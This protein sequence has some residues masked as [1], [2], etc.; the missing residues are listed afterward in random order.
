M[1]TNVKL[2]KYQIRT[3]FILGE[4]KK[5]KTEKLTPNASKCPEKHLLTLLDIDTI[6]IV[7]KTLKIHGLVF[8]NF[9][10]GKRPLDLAHKIVRSCYLKVVQV[11]SNV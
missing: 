8:Q 10:E 2:L 9:P 11:E 3:F 4:K 6:G 7:Y 1:T 5:K